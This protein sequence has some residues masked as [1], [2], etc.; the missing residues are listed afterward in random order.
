MANSDMAELTDKGRQT[1]LALGCRLRHLYVEQLK[2]LP[3][4]I[5]DPNAIYLR[6]SPF[7][8]S[9]HSLLQVFTGLYPSESRSTGFGKPAVTTSRISDETIMPNEDFCPRLVELVKAYSGRTAWKCKRR[10]VNLLTTYLC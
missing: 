9:M 5:S 8:R 3:C 7:S 10:N 1:T 4:S 2:F 6:S